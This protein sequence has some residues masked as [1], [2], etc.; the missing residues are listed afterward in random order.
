MAVTRINY[1]TNVIGGALV[2]EKWAELISAK[3]GIT[4]IV[5]WMNAVT[6]GGTVRA[7]LETDPN[8]MVPSGQGAAFYDQLN[9]TKTTLASILAVTLSNL[10]PG[11]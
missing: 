1:P 7:N 8:F 10:D 4:R 11:T 3:A 9:A 2:A 5:D 6:D